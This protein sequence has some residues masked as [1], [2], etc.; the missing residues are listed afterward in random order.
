LL[1]QRRQVVLDDTPDELVAD[2]DVLVGELV[3]ETDD[4]CCLL[5][6]SEQDLI[7]LR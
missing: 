3:A 5:D 2:V 1:N 7:T 6:L 4:L